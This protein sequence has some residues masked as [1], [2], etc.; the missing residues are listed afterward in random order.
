MRR[1]EP[2]DPGGSCLLHTIGRY[3]VLPHDRTDRENAGALPATLADRL[4]LP[5][6]PLLALHGDIFVLAAGH[7]S[8]EIRDLARRL[9]A[10][11]REMLQVLET[12][13]RSR[14]GSSYYPRELL[15]EAERK[16]DKL[17]RLLDDFLDAF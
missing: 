2:N 10:G 17:N 6:L 16:Y 7:P 4:P 8:R 12:L 11:I 3:R 5:L 9:D 14:H 1:W 15:A 13:Q